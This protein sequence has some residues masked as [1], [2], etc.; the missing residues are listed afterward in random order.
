M[1]VLKK[2][3]LEKKMKNIWKQNTPIFYNKKLESLCLAMY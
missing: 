2:K 3:N 1:A